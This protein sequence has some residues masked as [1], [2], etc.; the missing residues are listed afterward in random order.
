M[1]R[2]RKRSIRICSGRNERS[3]DEIL[4]KLKTVASIASERREGGHR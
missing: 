2:T 3:E 4:W 1:K